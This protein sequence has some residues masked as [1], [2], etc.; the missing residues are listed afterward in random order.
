MT[1]K[2]IHI[3]IR[4]IHRFHLVYIVVVNIEKKIGNYETDHFKI[5]LAGRN[6]GI[7]LVSVPGG[8][9]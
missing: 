9:P 7:W 8:I 3:L 4:S 1:E 2:R 5:R 6:H